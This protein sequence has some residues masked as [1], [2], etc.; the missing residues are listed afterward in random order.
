MLVLSLPMSS[1]SK[2]VFGS[3]FWDERYSQPGF[4]F[5]AAPNVFLT[6]QAHRFRPGQRAFVPGDGEGRNG[7]FLAE[8]GLDVVTLDLSAVGAEKARTLARSRGVTIDARQGN[9]VE[10]GDLPRG[11][12]DVIAVIFVHLPAKLRSKAHHLLAERLAPGG[13]LLIEGYTPRQI[14]LRAQG[15]VG[16]PPDPEMLYE[17]EALR[18]DFAGLTTLMLEELEVELAEGKRHTG[19]SAVL[20]GVFQREA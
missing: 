4:A 12:F 20:R 18:G 3:P 19:R 2:P 7:V 8:Q 14:E 5:G 13:L 17:A 9:M 16:G 11:P 15:S 6:E 1:P 10:P